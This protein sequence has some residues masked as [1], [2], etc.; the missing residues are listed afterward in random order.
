DLEMVK[1]GVTIFL[2]Y[3]PERLGVVYIVNPPFFANAIWKIIS[4]LIDSKTREKVR[5][6]KSVE[7]LG[8]FLD[9]TKLPESVVGK[10]IGGPDYEPIADAERVATERQRI[11][12]TGVPFDLGQPSLS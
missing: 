11:L 3:F 9:L 5:F 10:G 12:S 8:E 6:I 2:N 7:E 4:P 1:K